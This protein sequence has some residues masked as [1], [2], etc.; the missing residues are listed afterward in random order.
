MRAIVCG[1]RNIGRTNFDAI[2]LD[3]SAEIKRASEE[4]SFVANKMA[5]LHAENQ[6]HLLTGG[7]EGGAERLA[8]LWGSNNGVPLLIVHRRSE[9]ETV[10][11]RNLRMLRESAPE[12]VIA[13]G[14]AESTKALI[15]AAMAAGIRV[16]RFELP[17]G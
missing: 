5:A 10:I 16:L 1:G 7:N 17:C 2:H 3:A 6:F 13:F 12:L 8:L 15:D 4:R 9:G 14:G 11:E